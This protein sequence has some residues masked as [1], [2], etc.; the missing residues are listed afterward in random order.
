MTAVRKMR[1]GF[2]KKVQEYA[3]R[4]TS[5]LFEVKYD[6]K[7]V[8]IIGWLGAFNLGDEMMLNVSMQELL[9][10]GYKLTILT[11]KDDQEVRERYQDFTVVPRRPL[12]KDAINSV[13]SSNDS[14]LVN[15]GALIDD[16]HYEDDGSL[17]RDIARLSKAFIQ[18]NKPVV[19]YGVSANTNLKNQLLIDD[20]KLL[21]QD[22]DYFSTRDNFSRD[23]LGRHFDVSNISIVDDIVFADSTLTFDT[24]L[25]AGR[26]IISVIGVFDPLTIDYIKIFFEKLLSATEASIKIIAF[27]DENGNDAHYI[28]E[29]RKHLGQ[30]AGRIDE[31]SSPINSA[32]LVNALATSDIVFSMRYHGS[33]VANSIEK[34]V[35]TIEY[36]KHPHY[37][38]KN[39]YLQDH[40]GFSRTSFKLSD[41]SSITSAEIRSLIDNTPATQSNIRDINSNARADL[42]KALDLL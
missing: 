1:H 41:I 15:G 42:I 37:F 4:K 18:A 35:I 19:V 11:H 25:P 28:D 5:G 22:A 7:S 9:R 17:A 14:L 31:I 2:I 30:Q 29:I 8:A 26:P 12:S 20:Y 36:D 38:N 34:T 24:K 23:E 27:Y 32:D 6:P 16:R 13:V 10:R 39:K 21:V 40:Y 3:S 33:L